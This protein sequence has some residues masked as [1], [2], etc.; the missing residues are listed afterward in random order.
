M[1]IVLIISPCEENKH[2]HRSLPVKK[3][4]EIEVMHLHVTEAMDCQQKLEARKR[5]D[6][7][8]PQKPSDK[9]WSC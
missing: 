4:T 9:T 5:Q 6:R 8:L 2:T 7:I 3:E 1:T